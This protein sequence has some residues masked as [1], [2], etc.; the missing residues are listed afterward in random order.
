M[1]MD[2]TVYA[3]GVRAVLDFKLVEEAFYLDMRRVCWWWW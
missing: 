2:E 3:V 1:K